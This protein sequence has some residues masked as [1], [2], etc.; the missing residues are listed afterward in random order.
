MKTQSQDPKEERYKCEVGQ[1]FMAENSVPGESFRPTFVVAD[2]RNEGMTETL[3]PQ[4]AA[5]LA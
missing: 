1:R 5:P 4:S 3:E 2:E